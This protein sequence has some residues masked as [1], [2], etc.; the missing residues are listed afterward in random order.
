M[1]TGRIAVVKTVRLRI[2]R[3]GRIIAGRIILSRWLCRE[4]GF[5]D[6]PILGRGAPVRYEG[7][8]FWSGTWR[9]ASV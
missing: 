9:G 4:T 1:R 3:N 2:R 8:E 7:D 5:A 6:P